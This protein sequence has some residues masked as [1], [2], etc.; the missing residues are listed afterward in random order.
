[1]MARIRVPVKQPEL[2]GIVSASPQ[3][4]AIALEL[5]APAGVG[6]DDFCYTPQLGNRLWL[7]GVDV[8]AYCSSPGVL[9]GGFFY[10]MFGHSEPQNANE[11]ATRWTPIIPVHCGTKLAFRWFTCGEMH[12][13]FTMA[14]LFTTDELRF[15]VVIEN[16]GQQLWETTI[17]FQIA[18]G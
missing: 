13:H 3:R 8:W 9:Y 2:Q 4:R 10:L 5:H 11:I 1:M 15:G 7:Y 17:A 18:E 14:R 16:F 12:R 6:E